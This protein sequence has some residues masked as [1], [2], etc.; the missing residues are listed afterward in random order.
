[1]AI[2]VASRGVAVLAT[3][4]VIGQVT[5]TD[6]LAGFNLLEE[7]M[8]AEAPA[9][10]PHRNPQEPAGVVQQFMPGMPSCGV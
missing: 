6:E 7:D 10:T 5:R 3:D 2:L 1:M 4:L 8:E 9:S